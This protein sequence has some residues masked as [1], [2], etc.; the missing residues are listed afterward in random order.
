MKTKISSY[1][2]AK[3]AQAYSKINTIKNR[4]D[5]LNF[6]INNE[7]CS[8]TDIFIKLRLSDHSVASGFVHDL[9]KSGWVELKK[10]GKNLLSFISD[11]P[12]KD[13]ESI[14]KFIKCQN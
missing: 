1:N 7:G 4:F 13:I 11:R 6:I 10:S 9:E 5:V 3:L 12:I 2:K 8:I 14:N